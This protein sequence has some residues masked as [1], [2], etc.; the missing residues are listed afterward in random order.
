MAW[1]E[2]QAAALQQIISD[3]KSQGLSNEEIQAQIDAKRQEFKAVK[4]TT[5]SSDPDV[6]ADTNGSNMESDLGDGSSD[7]IEQKKPDWRP[8]FSKSGNILNIR[9]RGLSEEETIK[10]KEVESELLNINANVGEGA[11]EQARA[12]QY[13]KL[14]DRPTEYIPATNMGSGSYQPIAIEEYLGEEK[15]EQYLGYVKNGEIEPLDSDN[16]EYLV[17]LG[18][19][20]VATAQKK[21]SEV[22]LRG[23]DQAIVDNLDFFGNDKEF[24]NEEEADEFLDKQY[25]FIKNQ[26]NE[27]ASKYDAYDEQTK[28]YKEEFDQLNDKI[29]IV[30]DGFTEDFFGNISAS[31]PEQAREYQNLIAEA[32]VL[33]DQYVKDGFE[34]LYQSLIKTQN[35]NNYLVEQ[36][37]EKSKE[38]S[39]AKI[40]E[41]AAGLNYTVSARVG[42]AT[43]EF[44]V[45]GTVN[46]ASLTAQ[47]GNRAL[48]V[49][50]N[51]NDKQTLDRLDEGLNA[52]SEWTTDYNVQLAE[53][54]EA[55]I[56]ENFTL[57]DV[58]KGDVGYGTWFMEALANNSPSIITTFIPGGLMLKGAR[59]VKAA[60]KLS[61][62]F[63]KA[64][65]ASRMSKA[66]QAQKAFGLY[67][68][69]AA[70][71]IFMVGETGG[72]YGDIL[73]NEAN[74]EEFLPRLYELRETEDNPEIK[75]DIEDQIED[76]ELMK[77]YSFVQK[78]FTSYGYGI[79][80]TI[81]ETL[82]SLKFISGASKIARNIGINQFKKEMYN[83]PLNFAKNTIG[84]TLSG[85]GK[86]AGKG[87]SIELAEE[88]L[89]Q[90]A[91]NSLDIFAL[92]EDKSLIEGIDKEFF[93][94]TAVTSF[95]IMSPKAMTNSVNL[96]KNEYRIKEDVENNQK[97]VKELIE[98]EARK[99]KLTGKDLTNNRLRRNEI[100]KDLAINDAMNLNKLNYMSNEQI[101]ETSD[102]SRRMREVAKEAQ[103][104]GLSGEISSETNSAKKRLEKQYKELYDKK[105]DLLRA[106][107]KALTGKQK[108]LYDAFQEPSTNPNIQYH[109][110]LSQFYQN[111]AMTLQPKDGEFIVIEN[112]SELDDAL[113]KYDAATRD[114]IKN[115]FTNKWG[116]NAGNDIILNQTAINKAIY[117][118]GAFN[119]GRYAATAALEELFHI[120]NKGKKIVDKNGK[121]IPE[122]ENA[123]DE[124]IQMLYDKKDFESN[125][126]YTT[127]LKRF[128]RYKNNK[129]EYDAEE[130]LAQMNNAVALG[131]LS[132][133]DVAGMGS[134][135]S[136]INYLSRDTF[137]DSSWLFNLRSGKDVFEYIKNYNEN[138]QDGR[139][140]ALPAE[141]KRKESEFGPQPK[142]VSEQVVKDSVGMAQDFDQYLVGRNFK[143]N[144]EFKNDP[145][146]ASVGVVTEID[147]NEQFDNYIKQLI[148][149]DKNLSSL[150]DSVKSK[151]KDQIKNRLIERVLK[152]YNP[153]LN[154][155]PRSVFSYIFGASA[156]R[157]LGGIA[158]K[159]LLDVKKDYATAPSTV[160]TTTS[161]G[162]TI[163]V[164]DETTTVEESI[165]EAATIP[166]S[167]LKQESPELVDQAIEDELETAVLEI[168][169]GVYPDIDSKE[170]VPFIQEV[171][172]GKLTTTFQN[173]FGTRA[174]YKDFIK[175]I[176][177][178]LRRVMPVKFFVNIES[179]IKPDNRQF[180]KPPV[181]LT[182]QADIDKARENDQINYV[183]NEAQGVNLYK[184]QKFTNQE[185]IDF[186]IG[187]NVAPSTKGT[188]KTSLA[189]AALLELGKDIIPSVF[190]GKR[191]EQ[192][193]AKVGLKIS[194]DPRTKF[195]E[196][197]ENEINAFMFNQMFEST[198]FD[199]ATNAKNWKKLIGISLK[200]FENTVSQID[201][202]TPEG[203]ERYK[204]ALAKYLAPRLPKEFFRTLTGTTE[205]LVVNED[206][207][208]FIKENK[209]TIFSDTLESL[210]D[211]TRQ[212]AFKNVA[213]IDS[214][215]SETEKT[216]SFPS[217]DKFPNYKAMLEK[218]TYTYTKNK[219]KKEK[220]PDLFKNNKWKQSQEDSLK[221]LE[222]VFLVFQDI[223][224]DAEG[225]AMVGALLES[226]SAYQGHFIRRASPV[227]F[228]E[229][230]YLANGFVEEHT[231]P[232]S[233]VAKFL[234]V[235]ALDG[236]I[237]TN[238]GVIRNNYFQ[239]ALSKASDNKLAG[240]TINGKKFN[241]KDKTP[242]GWLLTDNIWARYFNAN[243]ANNN[244]GISPDQIVQSNGKTV[245]NEFSVNSFGYKTPKQ[246]QKESN[247][248]ASKNN[249][250]LPLAI[251]QP[252]DSSNEVVLDKMKT[253]DEEQAVA[254]VKNSEGIDLNK[255]FNDI[256]ASKTGIASEKVYGAAKA[257]VSARN[258]GKF[259][260]VGIPPSAQ[261]FVGL[262][263]YTLG[264]GKEGD[265]QAVWYKEN[266]LDPFARAM[267]NITND[268]VALTNDFKALKKV[269][270]ISPKNLKKNIP[271]EPFTVQD[272]VRVFIWTQQGMNVPD[273]SKADL[274]ELNDYVAKDENLSNFANQLIAIN[275]GDG[276]VKPS[277]GWLAGSIDTD[278][279]KGLTTIKRAKYLE[280][281]QNNV[282]TIFSVENLNKLEAAFG[283]GYRKALENM[284]QRM[285]TGSNRGADFDSL[286]GRFIDWINGSVGAIMFF[287]T[288]SAVLQTI[289]A[290]NFINWSDNNMLAAAKAFANQPQYWNDVIALMNSDFLVERRNGLKINVN[291]ADIAQI[292]AESE[293]KAKA[294]IN[295]LLK[296]GFLPTQ[297]ADSFAIASG[298]ATFYRNRVKSLLKQ[299]LSQKQAEAQAFLDFREIAEESQQSSRPDRISS[300]QA[301]PLGRVILAFA[302]T[303]A[304]YARLMQKA[305]SDLKNGRGDAKTNISKIIYYGA[306]QNII[307]NALQQALFALAFGGEPED[308]KEQKKIIGIA[309][310]MAD[311]LLRG[312]GFAG[313]AVATFKN[314]I[315][316]LAEGAKAQDAALEILDISPPISSKINKLRSAGRTWDWNKKEI[317]EK[318]WSL[319]NP[320]WLASGQVISA[321]TNLP[322]DRLIRKVNNVKDAADNNN[323]EWKR[324]ANVL[325]W[326]KWELEWA[327][328]K[329]QTY[330][331]KRKSS[332]RRSSRSSRSSRSKKR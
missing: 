169:E 289:S 212:L 191:S 139:S 182:K 89:T 122:A 210:R 133:E 180:T 80:A 140:L 150:P 18:P 77:N 270:S 190:L 142:Q 91:H 131:V 166:E 154:G 161:E 206:D 27:L 223:M 45:G 165:D 101:E 326:S 15:Y 216:I 167:K 252:I 34:D 262:L 276:Y 175:K 292:A 60:G 200:S 61:V 259:D 123:V 305:A 239:G 70:Q 331:K 20:S 299:G 179:S 97:L 128:E 7:S 64:E 178:A 152:S 313:A 177:P 257:A 306:I 171:L 138:I 304:Q 69:R 205:N 222:E 268:R 271:G 183:A 111:V 181:R 137:G 272:A 74:A 214:W 235:Q 38:V 65:R 117:F 221:G 193:L 4:P 199:F 43:E 242:E 185:L 294:F 224:A 288:R 105:Q 173:K 279:L 172:I 29:K 196:G 207:K 261:D 218:E 184:L 254:I 112:E 17:S 158:Q 234:F 33:E 322:L 244:F 10:K 108:E 215:I 265:K 321:T 37:R 145:N 83:V 30:E 298:G 116:A 124:A 130:L 241:Y 72:K 220:L 59:G 195:S 256:I 310:G 107:Q 213:E 87:I 246:A 240:T 315:I 5:T 300:Q 228:F 104:L 295:K 47:L 55:N 277:N 229:K 160:S 282:N 52:I 125:K 146:G 110:G 162:K 168:A 192:D 198:N 164:V 285:K 36:F 269:L 121:L 129:G 42:R 19:G 186:Y 287:N 31:S 197:I 204:K 226:T 316:K 22:Y 325:G 35:D 319:D 194:R 49:L 266:L 54:R 11:I 308:E 314:V 159:S 332:P 258:K 232:A 85:L 120:Q 267:V 79:T 12:D 44:F 82:G 100:L 53:K 296:L 170:F 208:T 236:K 78:A 24:K 127:L 202:S 155:Q 28:I 75:A 248:A 209:N 153:L 284:L 3:G 95:A 63:T 280:Q 13:F 187:K 243:V 251:K 174:Q 281:W 76:L 58:S 81:A 317:Y 144:D 48:Y 330:F 71:S 90:V 8:K 255:E 106:K 56:P 297:I 263:Y 32:Q 301:G 9:D 151:V 309:N 114:K 211:Y 275:K 96:L 86:V 237:K 16:A 66:L 238:F 217:I 225:V 286:T 103:S 98:L 250:L 247:Q 328:N 94:N 93:A 21:A 260:F 302:N 311:S 57:D 203:R 273:L 99:K 283:K 324:V 132:Q 51:P 23:V 188:R 278:L 39:G 25:E 201:N 293:N 318:G 303:P 249:S 147:E 156:Q 68:R 291:E 40:A 88:T 109:L 84:K 176:V 115:G 157:G 149:I 253:I 245:S 141:E 2:E 6:D 118:S 323:E 92:K 113:S 126:D 227:R 46:F 312:L 307:F 102:L 233:L 274:Q 73:I 329:K 163:D 264:K 1:T 219:K 14:D 62:V 136:F 290:A 320:A 135:K 189:Q 134:L 50:A 67:G 143:T 148:G 327:D 41:R 230:N 119:E 231:L 26:N